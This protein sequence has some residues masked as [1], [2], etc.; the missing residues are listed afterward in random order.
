MRDPELLHF[1]IDPAIVPPGSI[2]AARRSDA[3]IRRPHRSRKDEP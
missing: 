3:S 2:N 1:L